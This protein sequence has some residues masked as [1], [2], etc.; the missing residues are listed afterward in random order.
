M[1][2]PIIDWD[3]DGE[4]HRGKVYPG[5]AAI[6]WSCA[7]AILFVILVGSCWIL[8]QSLIQY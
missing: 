2:K 4:G 1:N 5:G 7:T 8:L 6:V 3:Y